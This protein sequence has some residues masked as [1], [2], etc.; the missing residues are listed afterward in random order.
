M[1]SAITTPNTQNGVM[2]LK[3]AMETDQ[4]TV[5]KLLEDSAMQQKQ[6]QQTQQAQMQQKVA[7]QT[8][9]GINLNI[10]A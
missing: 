10:M 4:N 7:Q 5:S 8:G 6:I 9:M 2:A 3:K 1:V